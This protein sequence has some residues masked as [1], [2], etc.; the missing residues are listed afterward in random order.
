MD[1]S[2]ERCMKAI[3]EFALPEETHEH[4]FAVKGWKFAL[5]LNEYDQWLRSVLK[6]DELSE[7]DYDIYE[8]CRDKLR[9][10]IDDNNIAEVFE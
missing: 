6:Y 5:A 9:T 1:V 10:I 8:I 2:G 3:L 4:E 7:L